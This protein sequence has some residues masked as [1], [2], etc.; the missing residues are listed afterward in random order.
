MIKLGVIAA[1]MFGIYMAGLYFLPNLN[2][3]VF[4]IG[5]FGVTY[6]LLITLGAGWVAHKAT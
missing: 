6:L 2:K 5:G 4:G 1:T 3:F